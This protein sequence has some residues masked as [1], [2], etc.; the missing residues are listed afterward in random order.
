MPIPRDGGRDIAL[1]RNPVT[2]RFDF[3]FDDTNNPGFTDSDEHLVLSLLAEYQGRYIFDRTGNRGSTL[4]QVRDSRSTTGQDL[5]AAVRKALA[6]AIADGRIRDL[7]SVVVT[8]RNSGGRYDIDL[9]YK[10]RDG[11]ETNLRVPWSS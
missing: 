7:A 8:R 4:Y 2:G 6:P 5:E 1:Q 3:A 11:H 9:R 10:N